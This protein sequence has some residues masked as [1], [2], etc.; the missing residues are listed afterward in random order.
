[1]VLAWA[2]VLLIIATSFFIFTGF[3]FKW[4][5]PLYAYLPQP[6]PTPTPKAALKFVSP[7]NNQK[8]LVHANEAGS[9]WVDVRGTLENVSSSSNLR[10]YLF[11]QSVKDPE[12]GWWYNNYSDLNERAEW[13]VRQVRL[14]SERDQVVGEQRFRIQAIVAPKELKETIEKISKKPIPNLIIFH[15]L[16]TATVNIIVDYIDKS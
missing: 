9:G 15:P 7:L 4:P 16:D 2:F 8:V 10:V 6:S 3:F 12:G 14:G 5:R 11:S 13:M 1:M